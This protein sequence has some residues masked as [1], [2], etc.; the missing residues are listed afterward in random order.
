MSDKG[1]ERDSNDQEEGS[2]EKK[3]IRIRISLIG[4]LLSLLGFFSLLQSTAIV[5]LLMADHNDPRVAQNANALLSLQAD[6]SQ[7]EKVTESA[8][9]YNR[10]AQV[11]EERIERVLKR[12]DL[13]NYAAVRDLILQQETSYQQFVAALQQG[14]YDLSRMVKGSRT[15]YDVYKE[16][17]DRVVEAS[18]ARYQ[19]LSE[20]QPEG[21]EPP[22]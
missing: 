17:L 20:L 2:I 9:A 3:K 15:W 14:M 4:V 21:S 12:T 5:Y 10:Q 8:A 1:K 16:D 22:K 11:L 13:N 19:R 6:L 18:K 7:I